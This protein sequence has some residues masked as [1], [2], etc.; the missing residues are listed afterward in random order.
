[1][2]LR[3][4]LGLVWEV[5]SMIFQTMWKNELPWNMTDDQVCILEKPFHK[6]VE[7]AQKES[8]GGR[9]EQRRHPEYLQELHSTKWS[10]VWECQGGGNGD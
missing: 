10:S 8:G 5:P 6:N 9:G 4:G 1:M 3:G 2:G 7:L